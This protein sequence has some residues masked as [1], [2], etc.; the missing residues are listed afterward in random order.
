MEIGDI[1][2][3]DEVVNEQCSQIGASSLVLLQLLGRELKIVDMRS[4]SGSDG[5]GCTVQDQT[6]GRYHV[7]LNYLS[8]A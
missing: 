2:R 4:C 5:A 6:G 7:S 8:P 3:I 1:V